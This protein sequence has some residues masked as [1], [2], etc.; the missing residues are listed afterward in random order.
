MPGI[1]CLCTNSVYIYRFISNNLNITIYNKYMRNLVQIYA[2][3][4]LSSDS[5]LENS[6]DSI[7]AAKNLCFG[8][9]VDLRMRNQGIYLSHEQDLAS[10]KATLEEISELLMPLALNIKEDG[11][12]PFVKTSFNF[13]ENMNSFVFDGSIPQMLFARKNSIPHALRISEYENELPWQPDYVWIDCFDGDWYIESKNIYKIVEEHKVVF[14][15]PEL[16]GR[17]YSKAWSF[18]HNISVKSDSWIGICTDYPVEFQEFIG[19]HND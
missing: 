13:Q 3:R 5:L 12:L 7:V 15:S 18:I 10:D 6:R 2:H 1:S 14:V 8:A 17:D 11:L 16:H 19:G 9:E 4:G